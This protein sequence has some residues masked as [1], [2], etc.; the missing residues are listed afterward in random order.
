MGFKWFKYD[1]FHIHQ[2]LQRDN[3]TRHICCKILLLYAKNKVVV[4][5]A[6]P[7]SL[8]S[9]IAICCLNILIAHVQLPKIIADLCTRDI[10]AVWSAQFYF[11]V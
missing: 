4:H 7:R 5:P 3:Y 1:I 9:V 8:I 6:R 10:R 11:V 2:S